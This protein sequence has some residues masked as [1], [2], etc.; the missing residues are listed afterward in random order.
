MNQNNNYNIVKQ[1]DNSDGV[2][3]LVLRLYKYQ[4]TIINDNNDN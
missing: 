4:I 1:S 3:I 2:G